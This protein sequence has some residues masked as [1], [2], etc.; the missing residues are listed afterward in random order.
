[1]PKQEMQKLTGLAYSSF[2]A[3]ETVPVKK[4]D[5]RLF[6]ME[7]FHGPTLAFKDV[8]LQMLPFLMEYSSKSTGTGEKIL[9]LVAT[10]GDTGKAALEGF[11]D[12][13]G[14]SIAVFYPD[15][16]VSSAQRLQMAT[17]K[18]QNV[19]VTAVKGNFDDCQRG[20]KVLMADSDFIESVKTR[21]YTIS[22][23]NSINF[24]RLAPQIAYYFWAYAN[25]L[26]TGEITLGEPVDFVV[27]T[28]N[29]GNILAAY[30]AGRMGL[31]IGKLVCASNKNNVLADFF[32]SGVYDSNRKLYKT[33][34]P[35]MDILVS[36]NLERLLFEAVNRDAAKINEY[37]Q[38]LSENSHYNIESG[39]KSALG[40]A[41][42][43][44]Y[45]DD[46]AG[47]AEIKYCF[48]QH[49]YVLDTHSAIGMA[50][51]RQYQ[52]SGGSNK[53][54]LACTASPYKFAESVIKALGHDPGQ[55]AAATLSRVTG[56]PIPK[57]ISELY[58]KPV[59][60]TN[61][62]EPG[63]MKA[64]VLKFIGR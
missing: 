38:N 57:A 34:S 47:A 43:A 42:Y 12:K 4:L 64:A 35:S 50:V 13:P 53:C 51:Y 25:L 10:S 46:D 11:A 32:N 24:G 61:K 49:G 59:L 44:G 48:E 52:K 5:N 28:G 20:V 56:M 37:M 62:A 55:D 40:E 31:P 26:N 6:A 30:Y 39:V 60:H 33:Q 15:G 36:S 1:M 8:A 16:G 27:P 17:Q 7:L 41:F 58:N 22:S 9:I 14:C 54:V 3:E 63:G 45:A 23:A 18:G 29:F 21:G 2:S 19:L